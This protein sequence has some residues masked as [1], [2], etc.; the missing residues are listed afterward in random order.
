[1]AGEWRRFGRCVFVACLFA[2]C[3]AAPPGPR[4]PLLGR[5][6]QVAGDFSYAYGH[7]AVVLDDGKTSNGRA[8]NYWG[9]PTVLVRRLEAHLSPIDWLDLGGQIGWLDG[10][11]EA[12]AGLPALQGWPVPINL[13]AGFLTGRAGPAKDTRGQR[14]HWLRL[15]AYPHLSGPRPELFLV[16]AAG[17]NSGDFY[18]QVP[19]PGPAVALDSP[20]PDF[21]PVV[22]HERRLET[23]AGVFLLPGGRMASIMLT[24]SPY[25]VLDD[26]MPH[27]VCG[28]CAPAVSSYRERWGMVV[29]ARFAVGRGF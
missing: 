21:L 10:G 1:M 13:A 26:G 19:D 2:G 9:D 8:D 25:F 18:H 3:A 16:L 11:A 6:V 27:R 22:R 4:G 17:L 14:S 5:G 7:G 24:I 29:V 15:E 28:D 23:S 12:R 20:V